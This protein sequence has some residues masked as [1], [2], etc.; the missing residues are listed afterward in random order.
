MFLWR[1]LSVKL[2]VKCT[3]VQALRLCTGRTAHRGSR[4]VALPFHDHGTRR[5]WGV[6]VTPRPLFTPGKT[7][8]PL[9]RRLGRPQGQSGQVR[10]ISPPTGIQSPDRPA[11]SQSLYRIRYPAHIYAGSPL[12]FNLRNKWWARSGKWQMSLKEWKWR[13]F[14]VLPWM[15]S[16]RILL[17]WQ[18][19]VANTDRRQDKWHSHWTQWTVFGAVFVTT[20]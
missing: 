2:K 16:V 20:T 6:S 8:Y 12:N 18:K 14:V 13:I 17:G 15:K 11:R 4:G 3:L 1:I 19:E 9:Y 10:K 5:G 7:L